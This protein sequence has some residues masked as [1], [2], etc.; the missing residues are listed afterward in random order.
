MF[1]LALHACTPQMP[2]TT[3]QTEASATAAV[4]QLSSQTTSVSVIS[5]IENNAQPRIPQPDSAQPIISTSYQS[6]SKNG[7]QLSVVR[8]DDR[9]H[10][11]EVADQPNGMG[12]LWRTAQAAARARGGIA[13]INGGFFT[14][15]GKP[16]GILVERG[17]RRGS[18]NQSSLGAGMIASGKNGSSIFR[19]RHYSSGKSY[20][21]LLQTG[22]MLAEQHRTI[23]GLS[24]TNQRHRS[25]IA[26]DG[27][28]HWIIGY[29]SPCSLNDLSKAVAGS[30]LAGVKIKTAINLDGGRSSDLWVS[31][32]IQHGGKTHRSFLNKEVRNYLILVKN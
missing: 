10:H 21:N 3:P 28:H 30:S 25:F 7:I 18:L 5:P 27:N 14:P 26:W 31:S 13:A 4:P 2:T 12:S 20:R 22:P 9:N 32:S 19:K 24:K 17:T 8:F 15:E 11:L 1:L 6:I 23:S 16:L 29:S